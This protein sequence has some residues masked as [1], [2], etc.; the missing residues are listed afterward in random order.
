MRHN[1]TMRRERSGTDLRHARWRIGIDLGGTWVRIVAFDGR[2][3]RR[4]I[5]HASPGLAG[6]PV[7]LTRVWHRWAL[8]RADVERLIVAS[9][10][11][12]TNSE[13]RRQARRFRGLAR[14]ITVISDVEAAYRGALG[15]SAGILLLAGTGSMALGR[16]PHGRWERAGGWGPLLGDEGSAFWIGREWLRATMRTTGFAR[17]RR[18]LGSSDPVA[19]IAGLAPG[20]L[21]RAREGS[22]HAQRIVARS[23]DALADLLVGIIRRL[24][25]DT[26]VTVSWS[27]GLLDDPRFRAGIWRAARRAGVEVKPRPPQERPATAVGHMAQEASRASEP[28]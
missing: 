5:R 6:L 3:R 2:G 9:R 21:R 4:A 13:R 20:V 28:R 18:I 23:Q 8:E 16:D 7:F 14:K 27:G 17:A 26:P 15:G 19:R 22:R 11:V 24:H 12:W 10:G 1:D 25:L